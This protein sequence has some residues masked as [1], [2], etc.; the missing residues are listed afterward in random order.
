M[1]GVAGDTVDWLTDPRIFLPMKQAEG[2]SASPVARQVHPMVRG[3]PVTLEMMRDLVKGIDP[4]LRPGRVRNMRQ[5]VEEAVQQ[6]V[7]RT[8]LLGAFAALSL[9]LAAIGIVTAQSVVQRTQEIGVR[10][11]LGSQT[12]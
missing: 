6:P 11:V 4:A 8:R 1:A 10:V 7:V 12:T 3:T 9:F 2:D 5:V